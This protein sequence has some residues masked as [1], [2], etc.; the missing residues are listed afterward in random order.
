MANVKGDEFYGPTSDKSADTGGNQQKNPSGGSWPYGGGG[1][2]G[3][4][5]PTSDERDTFDNLGA[6]TG[7][8]IDTL[9]N[10]FTMGDKVQGINDDFLKSFRDLQ[11]DRA[12]RKA[13][14]EWYKQV[15][16][17]QSVISQLSDAA[18]NAFNGSF[19]EDLWDLGAKRFDQDAVTVLDNLRESWD[20]IWATYDESIQAGINARN[21]LA[22]DVETDIRDISADYFAQ[23][24]NINHELTDSMADKKNHTLKLPDWLKTNFFN[25]NVRQAHTPSWSDIIRPANTAVD[26]NRTGAIDKDQR[27]T[28]A[29]TNNDYWSRAREGYMR[30]TQ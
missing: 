26:A 15:Q 23:G 24:N 13:N 30:R 8:N 29:S 14:D 28:S 17:L 27:T 7:F 4:S 25:E 12:A 20:D 9:K 11:F 2:G 22:A 10:S 5:S 19:I 16:N 6:V 18:G 1:G 3:S 21:D